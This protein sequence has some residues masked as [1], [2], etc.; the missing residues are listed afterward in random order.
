[1]V[2]ANQDLVDSQPEE[3]KEALLVENGQSDGELEAED[4]S[5]FFS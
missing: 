5:K 2:E 4:T 1:M 3:N